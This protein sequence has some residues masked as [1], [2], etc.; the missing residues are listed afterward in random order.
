ME[1]RTQRSHQLMELHL[2]NQAKVLEQA[3]LVFRLCPS[4]SAWNP[5]LHSFA[6]FDIVMPMFAGGRGHGSNA[7][8]GGSS[9]GGSEYGGDAE[10]EGYQS[11]PETAPCIHLPSPRRRRRARKN[12]TSGFRLTE[13]Q[14][15]A[16]GA[17]PR[18]SE[19]IDYSEKRPQ[20]FAAN[21]EN[22]HKVTLTSGPT[23]YRQGYR[24]VIHSAQPV[25]RTPFE[26][27][28]AWEE[29]E[30][31]WSLAAA[32]ADILCRMAYS[33]TTLPVAPPPSPAAYHMDREERSTRREEVKPN[34]AAGH[35]NSTRLSPIKE[36]SVSC[37]PDEEEEILLPQAVPL[38]H[39]QRGCQQEFT[40]ELSIREDP[41]DMTSLDRY[42][43][44]HM[45]SPTQ[46]EITEEH[47]S[48]QENA[49]PPP[50]NV[51]PPGSPASESGSDSFEAQEGFDMSTQDT[52]PTGEC[53]DLFNDFDARSPS[54]HDDEE[55]L[56]M[57]GLEGFR[58]PEEMV[59]PDDY[60]GLALIRVAGG[61]IRKELGR[62]RSLMRA[63]A[64]VLQECIDSLC[65]PTE[66]LLTE[67]EAGL[68]AACTNGGLSLLQ[69]HT[70]TRQV[71]LH[72]PPGT[73]LWLLSREGNTHCMELVEG[74]SWLWN[75]TPAEISYVNHRFYEFVAD[76]HFAATM[77]QFLFGAWPLEPRKEM[78]GQAALASPY[79]LRILS[80]RNRCPRG[81]MA[82]RSLVH[83]HLEHIA[84]RRQL[85]VDKRRL[86]SDLLMPQTIASA[87]PS[88]LTSH[89]GHFR[90]P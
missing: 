13:S 4:Q 84:F 77:H 80:G 3:L 81:E 20:Q 8:N 19:G 59:A 74:F 42:I 79:V 87:Q 53:V 83:F 47:L 63:P 14:R 21:F 90:E 89:P 45:D 52:I 73:P 60:M 86:L 10:G 68:R 26:D 24:V 65:T 16:N 70:D 64:Q 49:P 44:T 48:L 56:P 15:I 37:M 23:A 51:P 50:P 61:E 55:F 5:M 85:Q 39:Q 75:L 40:S 76:Y 27:L 7:G 72:P 30:K 78:P 33:A 31:K 2:R 58:L 82:K 46:Q 54:Q 11:Y 1:E 34:V 32:A 38:V 69:R 66:R 67:A 18:S 28:K 41:E 62:S 36:E 29:S 9:A 25:P 57:D 12:K 88:R 6:L 43:N 71:E 35:L 17:L 22:S